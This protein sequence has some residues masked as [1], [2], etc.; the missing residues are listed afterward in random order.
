MEGLPPVPILVVSGSRGVGKT[1]LILGLA[2]ELGASGLRVGGIASP[3][4]RGRDGRPLAI[5]ALDLGTGERRRLA[6]RGPGGG[7]G[8]VGSAGSAGGAGGVGGAG[9]TGSA[10]AAAQAEGKEGREGLPLSFSTETFDWAERRFREEARG[11]F[12]LVA[13]DEI[14]WIEVDEGRGFFPLVGLVTA[15]AG[16][17]RRFILT[18][19]E[20]RARKLLAFLGR[21]KACFLR[22]D[23]GNRDELPS[24]IRSWCGERTQAPRAGPAG[25]AG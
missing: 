12:D 4:E 16:P 23:D 14:G 11:D 8:G 1:T 3:S 7:A 20:S 25:S 9:D 6:S 19:R 18:V 15:V 24:L 13:L 2:R 10:D 21:D 5:D 17:G 22:I